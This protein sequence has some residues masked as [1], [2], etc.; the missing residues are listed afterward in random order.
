[1]ESSYNG[2]NNTPHRCIGLIVFQKYM[3]NI[4]NT[5]RMNLKEYVLIGGM[6][7]TNIFLKHQTFIL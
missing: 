7:T 2:N 1:M 5:I 6:Y 4:T 3:G